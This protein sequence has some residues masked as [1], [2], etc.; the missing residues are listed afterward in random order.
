MRMGSALL[1]LLSLM[2][3]W[4]CAGFSPLSFS[5][6]HMDFAKEGA[7]ELLGADSR[8]PGAL[9]LGEAGAEFLDE[10]YRPGRGA[11]IGPVVGPGE[12]EPGLGAVGAKGRGLGGR[13]GGS[14]WPGST[15]SPSYLW[16]PERRP[17]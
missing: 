16:A 11:P 6:F 17:R 4:P 7:S 1:T 8:G 3:V 2:C 12:A 9:P 10:D 5:A 14:Y 15:V 13:A